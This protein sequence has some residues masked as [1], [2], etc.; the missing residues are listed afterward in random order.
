MSVADSDL[1]QADKRRT[2]SHWRARSDST[3]SGLL[4]SRAGKKA[5]S[6]APVYPSRDEIYVG[7]RML[8][9]EHI[10][11][12]ERWG[13][14]P[15]PS[16]SGPGQHGACREGEHVPPVPPPRAEVTGGG[17]HVPP[18][19][20]SQASIDGV[21]TTLPAREREERRGDRRKAPC[22]SRARRVREA[23]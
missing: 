3:R 6:T 1:Q 5:S 15:L 23:K 10:R 12:C 2:A 8:R 22:A 7:I 4:R 9:T 19:R 21:A 20:W 13:H 18:L 16:P 14:V 11:G 17:A